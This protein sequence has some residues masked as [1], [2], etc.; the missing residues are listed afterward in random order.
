MAPDDFMKN[1]DQACNCGR[2]LGEKLAK[3]LFSYM[4]FQVN[5][6][7]MG[8]KATQ[9]FN[10]GHCTTMPPCR[11]VHGSDPYNFLA[12]NKFSHKQEKL[13]FLPLA[14]Q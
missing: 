4:H 5:N 12:V 9:N 11:Y 13:L 7:V 3:A 8:T 1:I 14:E 10:W 6:F 2:R